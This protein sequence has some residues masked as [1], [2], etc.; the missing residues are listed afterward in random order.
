MS[1]Q[2]TTVER[3]G[4]TVTQTNPSGHVHRSLFKHGLAHE[5]QETNGT[6][7][8]MGNVLN[9][10][11]AYSAGVPKPST[12]NAVAP[13]G[14]AKEGIRKA[15]TVSEEDMRMDRMQSAATQL[16][17]PRCRRAPR[18]GTESFNRERSST[19]RQ[20]E[21]GQPQGAYRIRGGYG[22]K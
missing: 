10:A 15:L 1:S 17:T 13:A 16:R 6:A 14:G 8:R 11:A 5:S 21:E 19:C 9:V 18:R 3:T 2:T 22:Y 7:H 4:A 12:V 20:R